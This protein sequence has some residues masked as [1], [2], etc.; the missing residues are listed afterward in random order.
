MR[1]LA[2]ENVP[3]LL[4]TSLSKVGHD[5]AW[6][7]RD[8]PGAKDSEV[9][10]RSVAENRVLLTFDKDFG[11][12]VFRSGARA[13]SGVVLLR[14]RAATPEALVT[15]C[16][17]ALNVRDDWAGHFSVIEPQRVRMARLP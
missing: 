17:R 3:E 12:L 2:N 10:R 7:R 13:S 4:V 8:S 15:S 11:E 1:F 6:I 9:L 14:L 5:V 16:V